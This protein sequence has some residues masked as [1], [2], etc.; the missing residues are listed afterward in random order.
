VV[1]FYS[2]GSFHANQ[3]DPKVLL[4]EE[5]LGMDPFGPGLVLLELSHFV[6]QVKVREISDHDA[7]IC[8]D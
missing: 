2:G 1:L 3:N 4:F 5:G 7:V 8:G 6:F